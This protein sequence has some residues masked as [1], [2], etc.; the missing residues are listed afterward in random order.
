[1]PVEQLCRV[2]AN[3]QINENTFWMTLEVGKLAEEQGLYAGQF[4]HIA[5]GSGLFLRRP[6]SVALVQPDEPEDTAALLFEVRGKGTR[7]LSQRREGDLVNVLGPLGNGFTMEPSGRYLLAGGGIG[8]APLLGCAVSGRE[9]TCAVLGFRSRQ[10]AILTHRFSEACQ[11]VYLCTDDGSLG[12]RGYVHEQVRELLEE[13][14]SYQ[15]I[16][17]CGPLPMLRAVAQTAAAFGVAC[18]VSLEERMACGVGACLGCAVATA[19]GGVKRVCRD[20]PVFDAQEV[21]W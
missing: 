7:W 2:A 3:T 16:L 9:R 13:D 6:I 20:G 12:R 10:R 14:A 17:A 8:A 5:C 19:G 21:M 11:A 18:Q 1:M 4:L 15:G